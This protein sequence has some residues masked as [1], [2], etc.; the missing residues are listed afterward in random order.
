MVPAALKP[1]WRW[2]VRHQSL[3]VVLI[4][5]GSMVYTY[6]A[7]TGQRNEGRSSAC[8]VFEGQY[9]TKALTIQRTYDYVASLTVSER[10]D[11]LNRAIL[12]QLASNEQDLRAS[13]PPDFCAQ[14]GSDNLP[15]VPRR[16][17]GL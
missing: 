4:C 16:P 2:I 6:T 9:R 11:K 1:A 5:F 15:P 14:P 12:Q 3:L 17:A 10:Q 7:V 8:R 13:V